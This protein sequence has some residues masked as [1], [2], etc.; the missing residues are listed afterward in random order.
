MPPGRRLELARAGPGSHELRAGDAVV[1]TLEDRDALGRETVAEWGRR[2]WVLRAGARGALTAVE[3]A[4]GDEVGW[5]DHRRGRR[6]RVTLAG[7]G[8]FEVRERRRLRRTWILVAEGGDEPLLTA[9][10]PLRDGPIRLT[11]GSLRCEPGT[12]ELLTL[13]LG[14]IVLGQLTASAGST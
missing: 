10:A 6:V 11:K 13:T 9:R 3:R 14:R 5:A 12:G 7:G 2:A 4:S 8:R 1:A